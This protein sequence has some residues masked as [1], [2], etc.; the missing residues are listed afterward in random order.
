MKASLHKILIFV[1]DVDACAKWYADHFGFAI[2]EKTRLREEWCELELTAD[3][4]LAFHRAFI[5]GRPVTSPTGSPLIPHKLVL[6]VDDL[7]QTRARLLAEGVTM[8]D[9]VSEPVPA[10]CDGLD[11]EQHRFRLVQRI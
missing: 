2:V 8:F 4:N 7:E 9:V 11:C 5:D 10:A 6:A 3:L 1:S